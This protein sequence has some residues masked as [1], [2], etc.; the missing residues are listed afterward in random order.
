MN[1]SI[2]WLLL[3][4]LWLIIGCWFCHRYICGAAVAAAPAAAA[5]VAP[6]VKDACGGAWN[7]KDGNKFNANSR[8]YLK[9][10]R[11]SYATLPATNNANALINKTIDYLKKNKDRMLTITG[12]Y[13]KDEK[14]NSILGNLGEARANTV[15]SMLTSKGVPASQVRIAGNRLNINCWK[16]DTLR[17]GATFGF[18]K[19]A[20]DKN[21]IAA[22]KSR[23]LGK[24]LTL[25]FATNSDQVNLTGQQRTDF[26]DMIYYLDNVSGSKLE[27]GGHTDNVGNLQANVNLSK[28]RADFAKTYLT[29]R[30][31]ISATRMTA[32]GFGPN[33]PVATNNTDEGRGKNRRVEVTLR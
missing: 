8:E 6:V 4:L 2:F 7:I 19:L 11:S 24:P 20:D 28:E 23:L 32:Q 25:Y 29:N 14:N 5:A 27:I 31:G 16:G 30:G 33:K 1:K 26:S 18:A 9:F 3:L 12:N 17:R 22:I 13:D 15:K 21:R 10:R